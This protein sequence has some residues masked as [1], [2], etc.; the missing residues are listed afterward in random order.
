MIEESGEMGV[1]GICRFDICWYLRGG[2]GDV[3]MW[4]RSFRLLY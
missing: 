4:V 1:E 3:E 2:C